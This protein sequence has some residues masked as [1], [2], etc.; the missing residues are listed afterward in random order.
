MLTEFRN[1]LLCTECLKCSRRSDKFCCQHKD[2]VEIGTKEKGSSQAYENVMRA[3]GSIGRPPFTKQWSPIFLKSEGSTGSV[4]W[5]SWHFTT[6]FDCEQLHL[7]ITCTFHSAFPPIL[8]PLIT[9]P[10]KRSFTPHSPNAADY[11]SHSLSYIFS[12]FW[13][14]NTTCSWMWTYYCQFFSF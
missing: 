8:L 6:M 5:K 7:L 1:L 9:P 4:V 11:S 2:L 10:I 12:K 3:W 14:W 13:S